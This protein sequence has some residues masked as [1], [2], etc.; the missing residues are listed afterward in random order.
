MKCTKC[1]A[2]AYVIDKRDEEYGVRRR[3]KCIKCAH[4][5]SMVEIN[6]QEYAQV[7]ELNKVAKVVK[8]AV[9]LLKG[10]S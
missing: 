5:F 6:M 1:G 8:E 10:M 9:K 2:K 7:A 4:R 3:Y